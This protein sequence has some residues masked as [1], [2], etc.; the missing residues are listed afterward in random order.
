MTSRP[1]PGPVRIPTLLSPA[2]R[3]R[4]GKSAAG[5]T[6]GARS[7]VKDSGPQ[8]SLDTPA[9]AAPFTR[10]SAPSSLREAEEECCCSSRIPIWMEEHRD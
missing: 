3:K 6:Y 2:A 4:F 7:G 10:S 1:T 8:K 5:P 9:S